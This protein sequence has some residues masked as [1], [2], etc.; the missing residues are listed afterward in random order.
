MVMEFVPGTDLRD[1]LI[2]RQSLEVGQALEIAA[3]VCDAL[4]TAHRAGLIHRDIKPEN[5]LIGRDGDVKVADFGIAVV[6][7][8]E[9]TS[10]GSTIPG[11][12]RYLSPEQLNG[13]APGPASDVW[14]AGA[15]LFECLTGEPIRTSL[16]FDRLSSSEDPRAPSE[17]VDDLPPDVDDIVLRACDPDPRLRF[18]DA[19]EM[20]QRIRFVPAEPS[21]PLETLLT[22]VTGE[23]SLIDASPTEYLSRRERRRRG[24]F[25]IAAL[26]ATAIAVGLLFFSVWQSL[27]GSNEVEVPKLETASLT[28][29]K[30][31]AEDQGL[32]VEVV[33][34]MRQAGT[35]PGEI[36]AQVPASGHIEEGS[37]V[38]VTVSEGPPLAK[39]PDIVGLHLERA[40]K[41]LRD[42]HLKTGDLEFIFSVK[43]EGTIVRQDPVDGKRERGTAIDLV[44]SRGP[45]SIAIPNVD[46][47][48]LTKAKSELKAAG[49]V[50][51]PTD[52][53]SDSVKPGDVI[54]TDPPGGTSVPEGSE[55]AVQVSAGPR[56]DKVKVPDVR[57]M[58]VSQ[59]QSRLQSVGLKSEVRK[60]CPGG[61][62]VA[63]TDPLPGTV[64]REQSVVVLFVC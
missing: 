41:R 5:I 9:V 37:V 2:L 29:A 57:G 40:R 26:A 52:V 62:T 20:S 24:R 30:R 35:E 39:V 33:G 25:R 50:P 48:S 21:E 4:A 47:M 17:L 64:V 53:Y 46:G 36:L 63:E 56:F 49:F 59:A 38:S 12:L 28:A 51:V 44:L 16:S 15:V 22:D 10:P 11:T 19:A 55:I 3:S 14:A 58:S 31:I 54:G 43:P 8:A 27:I 34:R 13:A 18:N 6:A 42:H 60:T 32:S 61:M 23:V 1:V 45:R 7:D